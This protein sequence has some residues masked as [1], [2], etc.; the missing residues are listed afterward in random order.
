MVT[1]GLVAW[2]ALVVS[3]LSAWRSAP[4]H[5][6]IEEGLEIEV[7]INNTTSIFGHIGSSFLWDYFVVFVV[8]F[9]TGVY[10]HSRF[11]GAVARPQARPR[12]IAAS[13]VPRR[14]FETEFL[15][16]EDDCVDSAPI[17]LPAAEPRESP[18]ATPLQR[19]VIRPSTR[20]LIDGQ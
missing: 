15:S 2:T 11:R 13:E 7:Y 9:I 12:V 4:L 19:K 18:P 17:P 3:L 6:P 5:Q 16:L 20:K 14:S 8:G 10:V 1:P